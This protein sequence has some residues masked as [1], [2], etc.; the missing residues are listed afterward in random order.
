MVLKAGHNT[1]SEMFNVALERGVNAATYRLPSTGPRLDLGHYNF[2]FFTVISPL[3]PGQ[4]T[5][6]NWPVYKVL[7][8]ASTENSF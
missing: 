7:F 4:I 1:A 6:I 2:G 5:Q 3:L 8:Y